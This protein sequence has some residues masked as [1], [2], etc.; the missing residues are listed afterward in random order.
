MEIT[1]T[2]SLEELNGVMTALGNMPYVQ[3][4]PLVDKI[5]NQAQP[6][7]KTADQADATAK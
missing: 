1:I 4:A 5:R 6:Q 7:L 3:A 2:L